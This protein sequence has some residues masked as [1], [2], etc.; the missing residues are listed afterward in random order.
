MTSS[1][2]SL[3]IAEGG[4][5]GEG[6]SG[7]T[8]GKD[9]DDG[10]MTTFED[11]QGEEYVLGAGWGGNGGDHGIPTGGGQAGRADTH[12]WGSNAK[13]D[14]RIDGCDGYPTKV[15]LE[16]GGAFPYIVPMPNGGSGGSSFWGGF[17]DTTMTPS[18]PGAGGKGADQN[19][20]DGG[21]GGDGIIVILE[22]A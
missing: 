3:S 22:F 19:G 6:G 12:T 8:S 7:T 21:N 20:G 13:A 1:S 18:A 15:Y 10:G 5:G 2:C 9:G 16:S 14:M 11:S 17:D 4:E